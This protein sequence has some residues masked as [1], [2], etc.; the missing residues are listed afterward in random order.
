[1]TGNKIETVS[2]LV[3][4]KPNDQNTLQIDVSKITTWISIEYALV[5]KYIS[6]SSSSSMDDVIG[7][8][9]IFCKRI[10]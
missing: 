7:T 5:Y 6:S 3:M 2:H 8:D 10:S 1:M 9:T 4:A